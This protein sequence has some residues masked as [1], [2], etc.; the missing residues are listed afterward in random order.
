M[1]H[2]RSLFV[3]NWGQPGGRGSLC[4]SL[5]FSTFLYSLLPHKEMRFLARYFHRARF[6]HVDTFGTY[7]AFI[8]ARDRRR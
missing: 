1:Y 5:V 4:F 2:F 7:D 6:R 3:L 8:L